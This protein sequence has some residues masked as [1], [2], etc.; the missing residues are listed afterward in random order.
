MA[1]EYGHH[2]QALSGIMGWYWQ[3]AA[4]SGKAAKLALSRRLELQADCFSAVFVGSVRDSLPAPA[5]DWRNIVNWI[6][7]NGAK[8]W[9]TNDHGKGP[10]QAYWL[11]RGF[12]GG[13]P[14]S[15]DTWNAPASRV[16]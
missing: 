12:T 11:D 3:E 13:G 7:D 4:R 1:H 10:N 2:V 6:R 9:P 8:A 5:D 16:S 15:C 14:G